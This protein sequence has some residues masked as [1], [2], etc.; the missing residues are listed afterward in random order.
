MRGMRQRPA[1]PRGRV[2]DLFTLVE[3]LVVIAIIAILASLLLPA[4]RGA[5]ESANSVACLGNCRQLALAALS[6]ADAFNSYLPPSYS[7]T[8]YNGTWD[9]PTSWNEY[10]T[11]NGFV[12]PQGGDSYPHYAGGIFLCPSYR[13]AD[14][15]SGRWPLYGMNVYLTG[16]VPTGGSGWDRLP[17]KSTVIQSPAGCLMLAERA[18]YEEVQ[19]M[20]WNVWEEQTLWQ[21]K[22]SDSVAM[23]ARH[24]AGGNTV[25]FDG[26]ASY[27]KNLR[28]AYLHNSNGGTLSSAQLRP[29]WFGRNPGDSDLCGY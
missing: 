5:K 18:S 13:K 25:W 12:P 2:A 11:I 15:Y 17:Q 14:H 26:H 24:K 29:I 3:L 21:R 27:I 28:F 22:P 23:T 19:P 20:G 1:M 7:Y 16:H 10:L 9:P 6:Y 8:L 4:L